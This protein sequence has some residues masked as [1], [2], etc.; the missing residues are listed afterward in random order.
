[1]KEGFTISGLNTAATLWC[2][3][4]IGTL[5]GVGRVGLCFLGTAAVL[6]ANLV[7]RPLARLLQHAP[8]RAQEEVV[9]YV[10][11]CECRASKESQIR[12]LMLQSI[13][14]TSFLLYGLHSEDEEGSNRV[15]VKAHLKSI[16]RHDDLLEQIVTRLSLEPS[17]TAIRWQI[18]SEAEAAEDAG[19]GPPATDD[20]QQQ[21]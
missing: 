6:S 17:V 16:G 5:A 15:R 18:V 1:L 7:L 20:E 10:F 11:E 3:A 12:A 8:I 13:G 21:A 9:F 14:H 19:T 2:T 4:A